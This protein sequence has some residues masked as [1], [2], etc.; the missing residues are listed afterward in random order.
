MSLILD[1]LAHFSTLFEIVEAVLLLERIVIRDLATDLLRVLDQR[2]SLILF[3]LS[4]L[5]LD[6]LLLLNLAHV[7]LALNTGLLRQVHLLLLELSLAG[8]LEV[9]SDALSLLMLKLFT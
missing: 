8:N 6:L 4:L 7:V 2:T 5:L 3:D 9:S 1:F